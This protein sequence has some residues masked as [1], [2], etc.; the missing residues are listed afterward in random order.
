MITLGSRYADGHYT[1]SVPSPRGDGTSPPIILRTSRHYSPVSTIYTWTVG[2]RW[3]TVASR[4]G[5]P[6]GDWWMV[7][8]ANPQIDFPHTLRPGDTIN[9]PD[10]VRRRNM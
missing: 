1:E 10:Y 8:D 3:D 5:I 7:L 4:F 2:D 9:I 6:R